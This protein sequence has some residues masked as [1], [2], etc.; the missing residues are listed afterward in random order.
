ML[1]LDAKILQASLLPHQ[2][3]DIFRADSLGLVLA[4]G[5][6]QLLQLAAEE[7][8]S[9]KVECE[10]ISSADSGCTARISLVSAN[11]DRGNVAKK[12]RRLTAHFPAFDQGH[13]S[14]NKGFGGDL[15][16][17]PPDQPVI[18][19]QTCKHTML[20]SENDWSSKREVRVTVQHFKLLNILI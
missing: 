20:A 16:Y 5:P 7:D 4:S 19:K 15:S 2:Y 10:H 12:R 14:I 6:Q 17:H 8:S 11:R 1:T 18:C 13:K 3:D 9:S